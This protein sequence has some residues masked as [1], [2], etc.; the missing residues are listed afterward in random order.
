MTLTE[1]MKNDTIKLLKK[2]DLLSKKN[3]GET[4]ETPPRAEFGDLATNICFQLAKELKKSPQQ[5]A[6]EIVSQLKIP[7]NSLLKKVEAKAGY[8][9]FFFDWKRIAK[10]LL[11]E[12]L[13]EKES[14]GKP[15]VS[16]KRIMVEHTS[17]NPNKALHIGHARN[18]CLG[19][20]LA[21]LLKFCGHD[22]IIAN[23]V[24]DTGN[25]IADIVVGFK[26]LNFPEEKENV[27]F[28]HYCG[29]EVYVKVN[30]MYKEKP[31]LL[32][33]RKFVI[34]MIEEGNNEIATYAKALA[35]KVL[36][37]QL[38]TL[39]RLG[40]Y[41][42]LLN[43]ESDII[44]SKLWEKAFELLKEKGYVYYATEGKNKGCWLFKLS[45]LPEFQ[46][47][48]S[49]DKI[50]VRSD[51]TVVYAGKDI[52]YA[53]WKHGLLEHDFNYKKFAKQPNG[54]I[55]WETTSEKVVSKHPKF[56][57]VDV[58]INVIDV[59]Q[60]YEQN[61]VAT[62]VKIIGKEKREYIHYAYEV[63]SLSKNTA[64]KLGIEFDE[65]KQFVH[66][67]GRKGYF[68]NADTLL[69]ALFK[70]AY[71]ETKKRNPDAVE[72]FLQRVAEAIAVGTL[73]YEMIK[74]TP[75]KL[76]VFDMD[77]ALK[78]EGN[79]A[80]YLQYAYTRCCGIL[81]KAEKWNERFEIDEITEEEKKL[82]KKL[83][84]F[85]EIV[86]KAAKELK[87]SYISSYAYE[88]AT[89]FSE[90]YHAC[91]VVKAKP[92]KLRDFR[93]SLIKAT[94]ITLKNSF[95]LLGIEALEKM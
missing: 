86:E 31:E 33:K 53:M 25:Q 12:I 80:P 88:L 90:F 65:T 66:M 58:S 74:M 49:P 20:C 76:M 48:E 26:F 47:L 29:D 43:W 3:I 75:E 94:Q 62:A 56:N 55:L 36:Q 5:L 1:R 89:V 23:Y 42:D 6:E 93:L 70:K 95:N 28:D 13:E 9:N 60:S 83:L 85:P 22:V 57:D 2:I 41:Y 87:P 8:I 21:R 44:H 32:E 64:K 79:T 61:V 67:S 45:H 35:E 11:E 51:G 14:F 17:V 19:D 82:I 81:R 71:E 30:K 38:Q 69:D 37:S 54:T 77:E 46:G 24:D 27:K 15:K 34:K 50:L 63:V 7:K 92:E 52:A 59:R 10:K 39:W 72:E 91:P 4:F 16:K 68:V 73:R 18:A 78:L 84:E 40:I